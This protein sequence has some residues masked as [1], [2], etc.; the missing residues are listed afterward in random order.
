MVILAN[1]VK[2]VGQIL[3]IFHMVDFKYC[4]LNLSNSI[5]DVQR[6][7]R[8]AIIIATTI[9]G[10]ILVLVIAI[11]GWLLWRNKQKHYVLLHQ[12]QESK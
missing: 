3:S 9:S 12:A 2:Y 1:L 8:R 5:D 11:G 6:N 4:A 10:T 7:V